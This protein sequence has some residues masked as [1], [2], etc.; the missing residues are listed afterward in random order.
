MLAIKKE[1]Q[2]A[3]K[4]ILA[5]KKEMQAPRREIMVAALSSYKNLLP[6]CFS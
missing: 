6:C 3:R 2:A 5:S 4:E 1:M